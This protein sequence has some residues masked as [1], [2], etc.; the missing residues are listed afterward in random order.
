MPSTK[1]LLNKLTTDYPHFHFTESDDSYWDPSA[2]TVFYTVD[3]P[4]QLL[5]ELSHALLG[6]SG[7]TRDI[8]LIGMERD[9]WEKA[10]SLAPSYQVAINDDSVQDHL[11]TYRDWLHNRSTCPSCKATGRQTTKDT[12]HCDACGQDWRVNEARM[13]GLKRYKT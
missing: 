4:E 6:H 9:A 2:R 11:D 3:D 12:Y 10:R 5:H 1:T 8:E 13:C 7:Y